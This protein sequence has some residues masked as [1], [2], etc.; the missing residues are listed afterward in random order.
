MKLRVALATA[1]LALAALPA[2]ASED[3]SNLGATFALFLDGADSGS[4]RWSSNGE[5][6]KTMTIATDQPTAPLLGAVRA[7]LDAK[8]PKRRLVLSGGAVLQK[9]NEAQL[10]DVR[11]PSYA[12]GPSDLALTFAVASTSTSPSLLPASDRAR[13][14]AMKLA[15]FRVSMGDLPTNE[16]TRLQGLVV[17][18]KEGA[19]IPDALAFDV[20]SKAAPAFVAWSRR[21]APRD[22]VI[23]YVS[24][25]GQTMLAVKVVGCA[26]SSVRIDGPV[27]HVLVGCAR[28]RAT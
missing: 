27:T 11:L 17:K 2:H 12:G 9:A 7:F 6:S 23:D 8:A 28:A 26:P 15:G 25:T 13:P 21:P 14:S 18:N 5:G 20:P 22:G 10:L 16:S 19:A 4:V 24:S 3:R 1:G